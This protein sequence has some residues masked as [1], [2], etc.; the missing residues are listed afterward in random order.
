MGADPVQLGLVTS[1]NRPGG[2]IAGATDQSVDSN[3]KL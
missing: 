2:N 3:Q 1:F